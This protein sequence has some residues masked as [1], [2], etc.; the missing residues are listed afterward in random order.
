MKTKICLFGIFAFVTL[1]T[2]APHTWV[3]KTGE[4]IIG[5]Y[6]SSGTSTLVIKTGGTNCFIKISD[7]ST[8]DQAYVAEKQILIAKNNLSPG[9][10][11]YFSQIMGVW[12]NAASIFKF[13]T[14]H[15]VGGKIIVEIGNSGYIPAEMWLGH[16]YESGQDPGGTIGMLVEAGHMDNYPNKPTPF[17]KVRI[18][19][20]PL[21]RLIMYNDSNPFDDEAARWYLKAAMQGVAEAQCKVGNYYSN[22]GRNYTEALKWYGYAIANGNKKALEAIADMYAKGEGVQQDMPKAIQLYAQDEA[23]YTLSSI[24]LRN[25]NHVAAYT[26]WCVGNAKDRPGF[27]PFTSDYANLNFTAA[28]RAMGANAAAAYI[29]QRY[30][31]NTNAIPTHQ[32]SVKSKITQ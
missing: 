25:S 5:D 1:V 10:I 9:D 4:T 14:N 26:W 21:G 17:A 3:L 7:L 32:N 2:A 24:F 15:S 27:A 29:A 13:A 18:G 30:D 11:R 23:Y 19:Q 8:N 28:E 20:L 12:T 16:E 6:F 22:Y 31:G